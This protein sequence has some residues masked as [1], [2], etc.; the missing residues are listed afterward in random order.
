M[1]QLFS[2]TVKDPAVFL[3]V[4][5]IKLFFSILVKG[6]TSVITDT[7]QY[8]KAVIF[9]FTSH[10]ILKGIYANWYSENFEC[11]NFKGASSHF[12]Q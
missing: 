7:G 2:Y 10:L 12:L 9:K 8:N 4:E 6:A 1:G 5:Y 3:Y 11:F